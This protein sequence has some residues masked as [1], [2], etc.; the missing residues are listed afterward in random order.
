MFFFVTLLQIRFFQ[1]QRI[2]ALSPDRVAED[3]PEALFSD[4]RQGSMATVMWNYKQV[5]QKNK[6]WN[7][8]ESK[9]Q[10]II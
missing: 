6:T 10:S 2:V 3:G 1:V 4:R 8:L 5:Q 7:I 9:I